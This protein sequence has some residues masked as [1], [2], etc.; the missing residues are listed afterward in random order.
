MFE[1]WFLGLNDGDGDFSHHG[2]THDFL[3]VCSQIAELISPKVC[4]AFVAELLNERKKELSFLRV[5]DWKFEGRFSTPTKSDDMHVTII[6]LH[7]FR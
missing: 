5:T 6:K 4:G 1:Y 7:K 3:E 2:T